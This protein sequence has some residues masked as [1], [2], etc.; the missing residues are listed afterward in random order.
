MVFISEGSLEHV[1]RT[2]MTLGLFGEKNRG[3]DHA[4]GVIICFKE[5]THTPEIANL[6]S[7]YHLIYIYIYLY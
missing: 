2:R 5:I 4:L 6:V 1:P 3:C 7:S